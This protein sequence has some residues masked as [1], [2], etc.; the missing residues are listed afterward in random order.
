M[1]EATG[2][3]IQL[4]ADPS[5]E[6]LA[7]DWALSAADLGEV[8]NSRDDV[9][10]LHF[11]IQVCA[12]RKYGQFLRPFIVPLRIINHISVQIGLEPVMITLDEQLHERT[13]LRH[14]SR[15]RSYCGFDTFGQHHV[16]HLE[17]H[18]I[19]LANEGG[20]RETLYERGCQYL[21]DKRITPPGYTV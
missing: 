16:E 15:I 9:S 8:L 17:N 4:P 12:L 10:K 7:R 18:L 14:E 6:E 1:S 19:I 2:I 13:I 20:T 3:S 5:E 11:A 21:F